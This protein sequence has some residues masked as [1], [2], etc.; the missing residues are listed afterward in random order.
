MAV[1]INEITG[2]VVDG[3]I[4]V[5]SL[6]GP[7]LRESAYQACLAYELPHGPS[8]GRHQTHRQLIDH[9]ILDL[10]DLCDLCGSQTPL[11]FNRQAGAVKSS[12]SRIFSRP[13][14]VR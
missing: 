6:L 3:A 4:K 1:V 13:I 9:V 8:Q 12:N 10:R 2:A 11:Y 7:G 5:H 14:T